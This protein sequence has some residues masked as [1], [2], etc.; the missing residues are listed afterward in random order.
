[1]AYDGTG[2]NQI[3]ISLAAGEDLSAQAKQFL[4]VVL[5]SGAVIAATGATDKPVGVLQNRPKSGEMADVC[6][7]GITKVRANAALSED[8]SVGTSS[9]GEA[10]TYTASDT[11]K[12]IVG[13]VLPGGATSNA[14]EYAT[15]ALDC[16]GTRTLA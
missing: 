13:R 5:S 1:M 14:G 2:K 8:A 9:D 12:H 15:I 16:I 11:T 7:F 10:A 6:I 3:L 4:F